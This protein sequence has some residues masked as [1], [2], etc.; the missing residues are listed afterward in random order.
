[1]PS[2]ADLSA[3]GAPAHGVSVFVTPELPALLDRAWSMLETAVS[4]RHAPMRW[5]TVATGGADGPDARVMVLRGADRSTGT[6]NFYSDRR[7]AKITAILADPRVAIIGYDPASRV[8]LR[9]RGR[10]AVSTG[11]SSVDAAWAA[12]G[13]T[14]RDAYRTDTAPGSPIACTSDGW[15]AAGRSGR[16]DF[17]VVTV[18][19]THI[20]SLDLAA[21]G[22]LRASWQPAVDGW[23]G[24][25]RTP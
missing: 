7:A 10:A 5:L 8:Q 19:L 13:E 14:G 24:T 18:T 21:T 3:G 1:M 2:T 25:W 20:E 23:H 22:H 6:L 12:I 11:G 15:P 17:A 16:A 4:D 9:L